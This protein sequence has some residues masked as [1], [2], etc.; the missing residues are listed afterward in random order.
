MTSLP[1]EQPITIDTGAVIRRQVESTHSTTNTFMHDDGFRIEDFFI[2][3]YYYYSSI[4][5]TI[6]WPIFNK[7]YTIHN[8]N[9]T[10]N[11]KKRER[12]NE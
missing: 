8:N 5:I 12:V 11:N 3:Y 1:L 10:G 2:I 6:E 9:N 7:K 4:I